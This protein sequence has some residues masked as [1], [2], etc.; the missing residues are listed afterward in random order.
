MQPDDRIR[1][2][3]MIEAA[4]TALGFVAGRERA[5]LDSDTMLLFALVRAIEIIGEA[6]ALPLVSGL[7]ASVSLW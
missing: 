4:E 7:C 1:I 5:D 6:A 2:R 3:H